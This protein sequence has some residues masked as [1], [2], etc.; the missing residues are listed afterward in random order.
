[1]RAVKTDAELFYT[2]G[3]PNRGPEYI[4]S[5]H[6]ASERYSKPSKLLENPDAIIIGT[7]IGA[8]SLASTLAQKRGMKILLLEQE[9]VPGGGTR[10]HEIEGFEFNS[11]V[12]SIGDMDPRVGRGLFRATAD[13]ITRGQL[14]WA[15]MPEVHEKCTFGDDVYDWYSSPEK[16][17]EWVERRFPG[18]GNIR[19]Y[20]DLEVKSEWWAWSWAV[21]KFAPSW[22]PE[23]LRERFYSAFGGKWRK[24]M[25]RTT[26]EVFGEELGFS[27]RLIA[28][29]SY[30]YGNH[31]KTPELSPFAFHS[32]NLLHYRTG[33]YY[34]VGGPSQIANCVLPIVEEAGGQVAV[35]SP[36]DQILIENGRAVGVRLRDG[37]EVRSKLV[38][39]DASAYVT[40]MELLPDEVRDQHGFPALFAQTAPSPAMCYLYLGYDE[41][42][43][44]PAHIVWHMPTYPGLDPYDLDAS[45]RLYKS[46]M[47]FEGMGGYSLSPSARDPVYHQRHPGKSTAKVLAEAPADWVK[48]YREDPSFRPEFEKG[49]RE[50]LMKLAHKHFPMLKGKTPSVVR[51]GVPVGC[52]PRAWGGCSLGIEPSGDHFTRDTHWLRPKTPIEGLWLTGQDSFSAGICGSMV[53]GSITYAAMTGDWLF[54]L[55]NRL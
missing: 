26:A 27:R 45:D 35:S 41:E 25:A 14:E 13:Y 15:K 36:V 44:L 28:I 8:L 50:N 30:M 39:S 11:G 40:Y 38:I 23:G 1:V 9:K 17:I 53:S 24:Y 5:E 18:E 7:G 46:E 22:V 12:D 2:P 54:M 34:P 3:K 52:N 55:D 47:K 37:T 10:C 51:T 42:I 49:V 29:F 16:N 31:G 32:V 48:R 20:Y 21:T 33:A 43:D 4:T 19:A 6:P